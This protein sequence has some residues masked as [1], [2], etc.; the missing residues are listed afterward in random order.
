MAKKQDFFRGILHSLGRAQ[1]PRIPEPRSPVNPNTFSKFHSN[2]A[3]VSVAML[4]LS[5]KSC[6]T[7]LENDWWMSLN[8]RQFVE[9]NRLKL[10]SVQQRLTAVQYVE[11][12]ISTFNNTR[13]LIHCSTLVEHICCSTNVE[14][15]IIGFMPNYELSSILFV[16]Y[17]ISIKGLFIKLFLNK[18]E[19]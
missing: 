13:L 19:A 17:C 6:D 5:T 1:K 8:K 4:D 10:Y 16:K 12:H 15:C 3:A 14:P 9:R 2:T 7:K 11:W 18:Y